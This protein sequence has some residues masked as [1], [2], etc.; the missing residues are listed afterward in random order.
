MVNR[1]KQRLMSGVHRL[2]GREPSKSD[3]TTFAVGGRAVAIQ[4]SVTG[5]NI[6]TGDN[7]YG[8]SLRH[9]PLDQQQ[10]PSIVKASAERLTG[11]RNGSLAFL[12][13]YDAAGDARCNGAAP[14]EIPQVSLWRREPS[15]LILHGGSGQGKTWQLCGLSYDLYG[16]TPLIAVAANGDAR[17][18][19][20]DVAHTFLF[21]LCDRD[22]S[23][24]LNDI[25]RHVRA[26]GTVPS[27]IWLYIAV[28]N[29]ATSKEAVALSAVPQ[30]G[31]WGDICSTMLSEIRAGSLTSARH[32]ARPTSAS[33]GRSQGRT[34]RMKGTFLILLPPCRE[35]SGLRWPGRWRR[36]S[37]RGRPKCCC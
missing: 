11:R 30:R 23:E 34:L 8:R 32:G 6:S 37:V 31:V 25:A 15:C 35:N 20:K 33:A 19:S 21:D 36:R 29:V 7:F 2:L 3:H 12:F 18:L 27:A 13:D 22:S 24:R 4:G 26:T 9:V 17:V 10:W 14:A 16:D 5:S 1:L 28:D